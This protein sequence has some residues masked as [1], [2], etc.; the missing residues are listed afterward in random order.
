MSQHDVKAIAASL[1]VRDGDEPWTVEE[2]AEIIGDLQHDVDRM[3]RSLAKSDE[4]LANL[5]Q[6]GSDGAGKDTIDV[7]S[8]QFERDQEMSLNQNARA[9][10]EQSRLALA[11]L[12][13]GSYGTCEVC[14]KPIGK[15]RLSAFP[16]ATMC[17]ACKQREE[18]R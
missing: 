11:A 5:M 15:A 1:P 13:D 2:V 3:A 7:G 12:D 6:E 8:S 9:V 18:R 14:G 16:R 17:V 4:D 10:Y